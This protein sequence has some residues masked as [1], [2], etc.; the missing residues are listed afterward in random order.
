[1]SLKLHFASLSLGAS[2]DQQT[3]SLSVF[4]V[5]EEIRTAQLPLQMGALVISLALVKTQQVAF[6][7]KMFIHLIAPGGAQQMIGSGELHVPLEQH[8]MRAVFRL[9]GLPL[10]SYGAHRF[11]VSWTQ[12]ETT[13]IGEALLDFEVS[14][15]LNLESDGGSEKPPMTH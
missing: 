2:V 14:Q 13:K 9:G 6:T 10:Q 11:V 4:E 12:G 3:G 7:G 5:L 15:V 8:R 1:M